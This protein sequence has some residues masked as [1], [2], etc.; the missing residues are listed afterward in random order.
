[1]TAQEY[2]QAKLKDL[3][4]PVVIEKP[5][6]DQLVDTIFKL[7]MSKKF[8]KYSANPELTEHIKNAIATNVKENKPI[9]F[10]FLH[11]AYKLWRLKESPQVDWA[12]L[13]TLMYYTNWLKPICE[14]YKPGVWFDFFVD[15]F[16]VPKINTASKE[17]VETYIKSYQ[18]LVDFLK[19][20]QPANFKMTITPVGGQ[21]GSADEFDSKL[22]AD[23]EKH[24]ATLPGSLPELSEERLAMIAFNTK[25]TPEQ[26]KD[27]KWR[28]K[29]SLLH[30]AYIARTKKETG[31]HFR[32][33]K[34][35]VFSQ[36][37]P[38]G[39]VIAVGTTKDSVMKFWVGAGVLIPRDGEFRQIIM[40]PGQL[41]KASFNWEDVDIGLN[42]KNFREIRVLKN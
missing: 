19:K 8:R 20:Y 32:P 13:F 6:D 38:S 23:V 22:E 15:D 25:P 36:P 17:E 42:A 34:I 35:L 10:T 27:H 28:E 40:S 24:A 2:L 33:D 11:G 1:M 9:N 4:K 39:T 30:D 21:F 26:T 37:L 31:Y 18:A 29:N 5:A 16:I 12:E 41:E 3:N 14:I 7:V